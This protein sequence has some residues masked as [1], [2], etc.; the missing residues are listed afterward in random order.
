L[1]LQNNRFTLLN[2]P[3]DWIHVN[4]ITYDPSDNTIIVSGR[5]QGL[6]KLDND[7]KVVWI[8]GCHKG[9]GTSGNGTNLRNFL[10]QP[11]DAYNEPIT[12]PDILDGNINHTDFEWCWY[13]HAPL[14]MP[15]GNVMLFDNGWNNRNFSGSGQYS[16]AVEYA[17]N[18]TNKTVKQIWEYGK[19][20]GVSTL[21]PI[22]SDVDYLVASNHVIFS[23]GSVNNGTKYGK[24]IEVDYA[25][26]NVVF[27]ATLT[28]PSSYHGIT[29][30]RTERINLYH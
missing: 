6:I 20:N 21:S 16:R 23:P 22:V 8:L 5:T 14:L 27:E 15:N 1:S 18:S 28:P 13:Q 11:L 17:I 29:F 19:S 24:V 12:N 25:S 4:A 30:H 10:L 3:Y 26:R 9:W 7:N 2:N